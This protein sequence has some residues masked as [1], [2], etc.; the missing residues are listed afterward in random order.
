MPPTSHFLKIHLY[1]ALPSTSGSSKQSLPLRFPHQNP[2]YTSLLPYTC[3]MLRLSILLNL[4]A[5]TILGQY[6]P[7]SSSLCSFLHYPV[8]SSLLHPNILLSTLRRADSPPTL[9]VTQVVNI[10]RRKLAL[11]HNFLLATWMIIEVK[12]IRMV[13]NKRKPN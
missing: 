5:R 3:Y 12:E 8:T 7:L 4:I 11:Q 1:N 6:R 13:A 9:L 2:L 10:T